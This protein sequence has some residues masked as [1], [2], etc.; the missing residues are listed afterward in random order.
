[1]QDQESEI[2]NGYFVPSIRTGITCALIGCGDFWEIL[3][4]TYKKT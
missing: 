3:G 2:G 1:M 4:V